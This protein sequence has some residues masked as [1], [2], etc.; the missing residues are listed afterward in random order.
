ML[1]G[2][3]LSARRSPLTPRCEGVRLEKMSM[4]RVNRLMNRPSTTRDE[5]PGCVRVHAVL[6]DR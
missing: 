5:T 1:V 2:S 3:S 6:T 4:P